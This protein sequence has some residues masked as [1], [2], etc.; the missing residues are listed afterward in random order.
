M[1]EEDMWNLGQRWKTVYQRNNSRQRINICASYLSSKFYRAIQR[2]LVISAHV[3]GCIARG[4]LCLQI[5]L[6]FP[7]SYINGIIL[8]VLFFNL[9]S[10]S[11]AIL[12]FIHVVAISIACSFYCWVVF[13]IRIC[14]IYPFTCW[15]TF[16]ILTICSHYK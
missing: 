14:L 7:G 3:D 10:F 1:L 13:T 5:S 4:T 9:A 2:G 8:Y 12:R 11:I 6:H 15:W 16:G